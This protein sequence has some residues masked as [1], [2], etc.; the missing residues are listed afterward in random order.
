[1]FNK[2]RDNK[3]LGRGRIVRSCTKR[4]RLLLLL[5]WGVSINYQ[6]NDLFMY[7]ILGDD[8]SRKLI[9]IFDRNFFAQRKMERNS[10]VKQV[11]GSKTLGNVSASR[12]LMVGAGG[13]GCELLKNLVLSGFK[14]I[15]VV[16][17]FNQ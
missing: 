14:E 9:A 12:V 4:R 10:H 11:L 2:V 17:F 7:F 8:F 16:R 3:T 5:Y 13:I 6:G 1:M 15:E